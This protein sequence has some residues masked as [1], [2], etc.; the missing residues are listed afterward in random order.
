LI[1]A[2]AVVTRDILLT[3]LLISLLANVALMTVNEKMTADSPKKAAAAPTDDT[4]AAATY[5]DTEMYGPF[6]ERYHAYTNSYD[7]YDQH[8]LP[9][10]RSYSERVNNIDANIAAL[11][12][13]RA[14]DRRCTDGWAL[15]NADYYKYHFAGELDQSEEKRWW[16]NNEW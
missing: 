13:A 4:N 12:G 1:I 16:G 6:W 15:K 11:A 8:Q 10:G 2:I 9:V 3:A 14:R 7:M 5:Q